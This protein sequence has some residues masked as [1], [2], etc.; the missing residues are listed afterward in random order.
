MHISF[1]S[2]T[3]PK[4]NHRK[5]IKNDGKEYSSLST[6]I[7]LGPI[8]MSAFIKK[9]ID[10]DVHLVDFNVEINHMDHFAYQSF[11]EYCHDYLSNI[12]FKPDYVGISSL[13]SP[14]L[15]NFL[16]CGKIAKNI[17]PDAWI[18]GGGNIAT[19]GFEYIYSTESGN[20]FDALCFGEGEIPLKEFLVSDDKVEYLKKSQSWVTK[21]KLLSNFQPKHS[22]IEDLDE[23]PFYDYDL[24]DIKRSSINPVTSGFH[25]VKKMTSFHIMTSRGCPFLCTF[26]AS[27]KTHGR[28]M[29]Y[30]SIERIRSDLKT[31][32]NTYS[33]DQVIF[34]DDHL[35][36]D[37]NRVYDILNI[38]KDLNLSSLYQNGLTL[39]ALDRPM[40]E[41]F[42]DAGVRHLVLPV[43]SGSEKVLRHQM[44]KPLKFSIS[45]RV[46][47]DCRDLGIYTNT[48]I[49]IGMPGETK[50]DIEYSRINLRSIR[51]NWFNIACASPLIGSE[52]YEKASE[53]GYI[54]S[55]TYGSD[56]HDAVITTDSFDA[57]Y[58][59][60]MQYLMNLEL[61]FVYN[62]DMLTGD[63]EN[64]LVGF[65][66]VVS[67]KND[68]ALAHYYSALCYK[69][70]GNDKEYLNSR[71]L[72]DK[73]KGSAPWTK[74]VEFFNLQPI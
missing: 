18:L 50:E 2:F 9:F 8:S 30:H 47:E 62:Q 72:F 52:M 57:A 26:C 61:N 60:N 49:I 13:F 70:L 55:G 39:Y 44:R 27:H 48:N 37:K 74:W 66:N 28:K 63:Y 34:Q 11:E 20:N 45:Q 15:E 17:W 19:N 54:S 4:N 36:A 69:E 59:Q 6:D 51:T 40:L 12:Y 58:I 14:S 1:E 32:V 33:A 73:F 22:F 68:H 67:I 42:F 24:I 46:A 5:Y 3:S 31:L 56:F 64:A 65:R 7:P 23:I 16:A 43:E 25:N 29:R 41:A 35:M 53:N 38:V 21:E 10:I 71:E